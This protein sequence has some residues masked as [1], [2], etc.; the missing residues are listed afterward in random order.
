MLNKLLLKL[1]TPT[2]ERNLKFKNLHKGESCYIFGDGVSL[3]DMNLENFS[4]KVSFASNLLCFHNN[5]S[6]LNV[7]YYV[8]PAA[9]W[10]FYFWRN[11]YTK[12]I[13]F[14]NI[15]FLQRR[16]QRQNK[17]INFFINLSNAP[18]LFRK[19]IFYFHHFGVN[20]PSQKTIDLSGKFFTDG[21]LNTMLGMAIYMG[22][23]EA[24]LVG[25]DY[26]H[27]PQRILHFY[28]KGKGKIHYDDE[29]NKVFFDFAKKQIKLKT[30]TN[31]ESSSKILDYATYQDFTGHSESYKENT[32]II[33]SSILK[34]INSIDGYEVL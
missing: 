8:M 19:N 20:T 33:D 27:S 7:K 23:S 29:Y 10:F 28:E 4:D 6:K 5:F 30:I 24:Y 21:A 22:F 31:S 25:C 16:F 2:L 18:V 14:N 1:S 3:K 34:A 11:P 32:D 26:T 17:H 12:K 13:F 9:Y 15:S